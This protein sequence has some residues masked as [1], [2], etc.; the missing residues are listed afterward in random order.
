MKQTGQALADLRAHWASEDYPNVSEIAKKANVAR[1][2]A[3]RYLTGVTKGGA[4]ETIRALAIAM[5]RPDIADSI[6]YKG[7]GDMSNTEDYIAELAQQ[8]QEKTQQQLTDAHAR[9]KQE[10]EELTGN[11]RL[12][13]QEWY[14][15]RE[16][17]HKENENLRA[18]FDKAVS[19]RDAQ[20][21]A[22]RVEKYVLFVILVVSVVMHIA[23]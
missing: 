4:P 6:P 10:L 11:H 5:N 22:Q 7:F 2:T 12:E 1:G 14:K 21:K 8:W 15:Q 16:S 19:F 20:L 17:L 9:H 3:H 18:S 13:R 23:R